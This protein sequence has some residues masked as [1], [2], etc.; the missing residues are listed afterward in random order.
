M[1]ISAS[2][3]DLILQHLKDYGSITPLV[4]MKEY[5]ILRLAARISNLRN[6]GYNI[7]TSTV[8]TKNKAGNPV[9]FAKYTLLEGDYERN[10][11]D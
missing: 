3:C 5:G 9:N 6:S 7:I 2:Q 1:D 11:M 4:A 8:T 10:K